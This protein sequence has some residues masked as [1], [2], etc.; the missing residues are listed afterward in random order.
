LNAVI[1]SAP[2]ASRGVNDERLQVLLKML[3]AKLTYCVDGCAGDFELRR[4]PLHLVYVSTTGVYGDCQGAWVDENSVVAPH[5]ARAIRRVAAEQLCLQWAKTHG[6]RVRLSILRAPG[7][8]AL[9]RLPV[10]QLL[11]G[12]VVL[13]ETDDSVSNH[14]HA[15][16][17]AR[18]LVFALQCPWVQGNIRLWNVC[19][20]EPLAMAVWY[21][22]LANALGLPAPKTLS[23]AQMQAQVSPMRWSFMCESRRVS[24]QALKQ[25]GF[26][27]QHP[28]ATA[29]V[30]QYAAQIRAHYQYLNG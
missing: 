25:A 20:D 15:D 18:A 8:Y 28:R 29:F 30:Q 4:A 6:E 12:G 5:S 2:P 11:A 23:R 16:D 3:D 7:I 13:S 1:Y 22:V 17:L 21:G 26:V 27:W 9:E 14:I 24:N 19:D 10:A